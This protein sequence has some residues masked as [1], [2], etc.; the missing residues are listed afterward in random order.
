MN[1]V[2]KLERRSGLATRWFQG[3][4]MCLLLATASS[5]AIEDQPTP[6][7]GLRGLIPSKAPAGLQSKDF[8]L[9][10]GRWTDWGNSTIELVEKFYSDDALDI[11]AQRDLLAQLNSKAGVMQ[12]ALN[13]PAYAQLHGPLADLHGRLVRR[14]EFGSAILDVLESDPA[15]AQRILI[16]NSYSQLKTA[17]SLVRSDLSSIPGGNLWVPY[18][19]LDAVENAASSNDTSPAAS[20]LFTKVVAKLTPAPEWTEAQK[21]FLARS[22][23]ARLS[24]AIDSTSKTIPQPDIV[25]PRARVRELAG[26]FLTALDE[27]ESNGST[28]GATNARVA[29]AEL[30]N[31]APDG[32]AK[33]AELM[34]SHYY[35]Y[36]LRIIASEGLLRRVMND[37][38]NESSWINQCI[39]GARINGSQCTN[40][41]IQVDLRPNGDRASI[42]LTVDGTVQSRTTGFTDQATVFAN[43][44]H[45]FHAEKGLSYDGHSFTST[46]ASV[47]VRA[48]NRIYAAQSNFSGFPILGRIADGIALD[49]AQGKAGQANAYTANQIRNEAGPRLDSEAQSKFDKANL[50][51]ETRVWGPLRE[52]GMYPDTMHWSSSDSDA[53]VRTRLMDIDELGGA[54]PAPNITLP[55]DGVLIQVHESL[56]S[57]GAD[58][59]EFAGRTLKESEVRKILEE[60]LSKLLGRS[61]DIADPVVAAG[62]QPVDNTLMFDT[63]DPIRFQIDGG[64]VKFIMRAGLKPQKGDEIPT[65]IITVPLSFRVVGN[66]ILMERGNVG[67]KPIAPVGNPGLQIT[68]GGVMRQNI[69]RAFTNKSLKGE[70]EREIQGKIVHLSI[71]AIDARD[72][73]LSVQAR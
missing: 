63:V 33:L 62:E 65:Q 5:W 29:F 36:N 4:A 21:E 53:L 30:R 26:V 32:G 48:N 56:M 51:L 12:T 64:Q 15:V 1:M 31:I 25:D 70:F 47:G 8:E 37:N 44:N 35:N 7:I 69:Q 3:G 61:V 52:Q 27:Y 24:T 20:E 38:R 23:L 68:R 10:D 16:R 58:R 59:F 54:N 18:L 57:N 50:E 43:G 9:L 46:P 45:H 40:T 72:G 2:Q 60:R 13:D 67:V 71:I 11:P 55:A 66:Q 28:A 41:S 34:R 73:W 19:D 39:M 22:S 49:V 6:A 14:I 17:I 42:A